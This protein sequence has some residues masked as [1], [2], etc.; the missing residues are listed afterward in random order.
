MTGRDNERLGAYGE[1]AAAEYLTRNGY[2]VVARNVRLG[3]REID[4]VAE[5]DAHVCFVEVK[6]RTVSSHCDR[7]T[8]YLV[9]PAAA[10]NYKKRQNLLSAAREYL[11]AHPSG[12]FPRLDVIEIYVTKDPLGKLELKNVNH[13]RNAF[14]R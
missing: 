4:I 8:R 7:D 10:V 14:G 1:D 6:T 2:S 3:K 9:A 12:K 5:D 11:A 13:V